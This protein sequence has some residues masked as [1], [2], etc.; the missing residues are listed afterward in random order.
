LEKLLIDIPVYQKRSNLRKNKDL[1]EGPIFGHILR[2]ALPMMIGM[3]SHMLLSIIDGIFVSR[4][5]LNESL[6]VL[7]Y[8]FPFFYLIF[9]VFNGVTSGST[10]VLARLLGAKEKDKA[11]NAL[12]QIV[13][14]CVGIFVIFVA[15]YPF[16][17]PHYLAMQKAS[18]ESAT[19]TRQYL[20]FMFLG[21]PFLILSLIWGSGLRAEGNTRTL[22]TGMM[23]GTLIN[24]AIAPF[25]IFKDFR[26]LGIQWPGLG[27]SVTGAGLASSAA[28]VLTLAVVFS[29]YGRGQSVLK[30][31]FWPDW[32][33]RSGLV[34]AFSVGLPSI[35]SQS[36][37]GVNL[38]IF[39]RLATGFGPHAV[40]AIGIGS[41][42]EIF[43]A[44][45]SLSIMVAVLSLV[46]QNFGAKK[47]ARVEQSVRTGLLT[48]FLTLATIGL[49]VHFCRAG[50]IAKFNPDPQTFP[51]AYHFIGITTLGYAF[52]GISIVSSGAFQGLGRGLPF[53]L[54]NLTRMVF[55]AA[56]LGYFLARTRGEYAMHYAPLIAGACTSLVAACWILAA[57]NRL[58]RS[59]EAASASSLP[60]GA[61]A[62]A[63]ST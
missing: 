46:G 8:G 33:E 60:I 62:E 37:I 50:L 31:R 6:A 23:V 2:M 54:L 17:I 7:N 30:L 18:P 24:I 41:R 19:L 12:S 22:M 27:L 5:G 38:F 57:V 48:A 21:V 10:S 56:P 13:W 15:I 40:S 44:F 29:I 47:Y 16:A 11:E 52:A 3:S 25:L 51:S 9:A 34:G 20:N 45:P 1:T 43:A 58:K 61:A 55:I 28:N 35:I 42:L 4:L 63:A 14:V 26:F 49:I 39:T 32:K 53:L 59:S 36:L